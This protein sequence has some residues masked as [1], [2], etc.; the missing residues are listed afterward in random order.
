MEQQGPDAGSGQK[1][2]SL[3]EEGQGCPKTISHSLPGTACGTQPDFCRQALLYLWPSSSTPGGRATSVPPGQE[4]SAATCPHASLST[5]TGGEEGRHRGMQRQSGDG[6]TGNA[7]WAGNSHAQCCQDRQSRLP[8]RSEG[9]GLPA[10]AAPGTGA[11]RTP[12]PLP[13][14][15][16]PN[17]PPPTARP[18]V[19]SHVS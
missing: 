1:G 3:T 11:L 18:T 13:R 7:G 4:T 9:G 8:H 10:D 2:L 14:L 5:E 12:G 15:C 6:G 17:R 16:L 19:P